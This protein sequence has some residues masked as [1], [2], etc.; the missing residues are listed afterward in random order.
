[1]FTNDMAPNL[2]SWPCTSMPPRMFSMSFECYALNGQHFVVQFSKANLLKSHFSVNSHV[3]RISSAIQSNEHS[4]ICTLFH[5]LETRKPNCRN[6]KLNEIIWIS[7][8]NHTNDGWGAWCCTSTTQ[9]QIGQKEERI[10]D[11]VAGWSINRWDWMRDR[12]NIIEKKNTTVNTNK[13]NKWLFSNKNKFVLLDSFPTP[14]TTWPIT[15][16]MSIIENL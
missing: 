2:K 4:A 15:A 5:S 8:N 7:D 12:H 14:L 16:Y 11:T 6:V 1:M 3:Q 10:T 9:N 13:C